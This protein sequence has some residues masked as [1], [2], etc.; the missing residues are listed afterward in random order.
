MTSDA[1]ASTPSPEP[2]DA[3]P[4]ARALDGITGEDV[5]LLVLRFGLGVVFLGHGLQKLGWF[6]GGLGGGYP[7]S[8]SAEKDLLLLW[9]YSSTGLLA[10]VLTITEIAAGVSLLLGLLTPLG[11]AG[12]IGIMWQFVAGLQWQYGLFAN[13]T[14]E[15][16]ATTIPAGFEYTLIILTAAIALAFTGPGRLSADRALGLRLRGMRWGL[17]GTALGLVVGTFVLVVWGHGL[18]RSLPPSG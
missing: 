12:V 15:L 16:N 18:G 14:N 2:H 10:W 17:I 9:H 11:A 4:S 6:R 13:H 8:I 5:G 1:G 7:A 3:G